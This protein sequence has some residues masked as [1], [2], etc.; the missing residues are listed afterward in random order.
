MK[1]SMKMCKGVYMPLR[2]FIVSKLQNYD[3]WFH[4][5]SIDDF[6]E[7]YAGSIHSFRKFSK[8]FQRLTV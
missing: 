3:G 8:K 2:E 4:H 1:K 6:Q 7:I 5:E